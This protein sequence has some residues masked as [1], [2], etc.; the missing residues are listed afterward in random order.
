MQADPLSIQGPGPGT[1]VLSAW[2]YLRAMGLIYMAAF[3]SLGMQIKGL[4]GQ[5]GILPAGEFLES[6]RL[7]KSDRCFALYPTLCWWNTSDRFLQLLC[8]GGAVLAAMLVM[9]VAPVP[10]LIILWVAY[11]SLF[12]VSRVFLG[13]QWD[14]LLLEMG[15]L[16]IFI[17]PFDLAPHWPPRY[18]PWNAVRWLHYWLLFR[19]MFASG[20]VKLRSG[21][22][23]WRSLTAL[24]FHY[25]T[26]P[27]PNRVS[28]YVH[29]LPSWFHKMSAVLM[30]AI[31]LGL[32]F[33]I[34][35]PPPFR[36]VA[37][38]GIIVLML[39]IMITGNYCF[40]N[41]QGLAL[42]ALLFD[43][44]AWN[45]IFHI[46]IAYWRAVVIS[47]VP[48][49]WPIVIIILVQLLILILSADR[50]LRLFR[51]K[52]EWPAQV[53]KIL[54]A[55]QPFGLVN[56]YGLFAVMTT[57]RPE[58]IVEGSRDGVNWLPYEFKW[59][60]EDVK[61]APGICIPHQPRL[62][63]QMWFAALGGSRVAPWFDHFRTR[64]LEGSPEVLALLK[65]NPF[66]DQ[67][68]R[69]VRAVYYDYRF[70][71]KETRLRSG[72]WWKRERRGLYS[73]ET[74]HH[75]R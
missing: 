19:L 49:N 75:S 7:T 47:S 14:V 43:D 22:A 28:W 63:W 55:T 35:A 39:L 15:F 66:P 12:T 21:D 68:P 41:L 59:K 34:F 53:E 58:I 52:F 3:V 32:P 33:L 40:F 2:V 25:E 72:D 48:M 56:N 6:N 57:E 38:W 18:E 73:P 11:L 30:F 8:W 42:C 5:R 64:L 1:Y 54:A 70:T 17:A 9:G 71:D 36:Y 60:A 46:P 31:E 67:P 74:S 69:F 51:I 20:V 61:R 62:D 27:L 45:T 4:V 37:A 16:A 24:Q 26:Q 10:I 13:Y 50:M 23:T 65:K 44:A 29:Q